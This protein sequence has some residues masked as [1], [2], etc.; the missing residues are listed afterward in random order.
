MSYQRSTRASKGKASTVGESGGG[1]AAAA[2]GAPSPHPGPG[3]PPAGEAA[4]AEEEEA[5]A[6]REAE[7]AELAEEIATL[8]I[9]AL[10]EELAKMDA[11][12]AAAATPAEPD[13]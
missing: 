10:E 7:K 9:V 8:K 6:R 5:R 1:D 2:G 12:A 11:A 4:A 3:P 13:P